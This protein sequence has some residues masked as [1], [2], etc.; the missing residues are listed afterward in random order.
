MATKKVIAVKNVPETPE[1]DLVKK[2]VTFY[3]GLLTFKRSSKNPRNAESLS[4]INAALC[5]GFW[6]QVRTSEDRTRGS[7]SEC[8]LEEKQLLIFSFDDKILATLERVPLS[9]KTKHALSVKKTI[10]FYCWH[11]VASLLSTKVHIYVVH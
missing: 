3:F 2:F 6:N 11:S 5:F 9:T 8:L 7:S 4:A 10:S 1:S